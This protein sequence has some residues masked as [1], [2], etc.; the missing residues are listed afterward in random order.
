MSDWK[1]L[2]RPPAQLP[3]GCDRFANHCPH[4]SA[5]KHPV[6]LNQPGVNFVDTL[7]ELVQKLG[8]VVVVLHPDHCAA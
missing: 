6:D 3:C 2:D 8:C 1:N 5:L 4:G 7:L